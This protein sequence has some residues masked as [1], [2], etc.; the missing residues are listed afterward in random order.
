M[1][2][3]EFGEGDAPSPKPAMKRFARNIEVAQLLP[4]ESGLG[5]SRY[6]Q[7]ST[8]GPGGRQFVASQ[9]TF[10]E[11]PAGVY[12]VVAMDNLNR[13]I[14]EKQE[15]YVDDLIRMKDCISDKILYEIEDFWNRADKFKKHGILH[16]RGYL[17]YGSQG[18]GKTILVQQIISSMVEKGYVVFLCSEPTKALAGLKDFRVIEPERRL[19]CVFEDI[20]ALFARYGD[21]T[22]LSLLDGENQL[23]HTLNLATSN[24]PERLEKRIVCRPRRFDRVIKIDMPS[25]T[26]REQYFMAKLGNRSNVAE[27]VK[28]S[29]GL[30]FA[31][32]AELVVSVECLG[33]GLDE[34]VA[35]L[36]EMCRRSPSSDEFRGEVGFRK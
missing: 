14:L 2:F 6:T 12:V 29:E 36:A 17:L 13:P 32:L 33:R 21:E 4:V 24:Y 22:L 28:K 19:A 7:W 25:E 11:L 30:S 9:Q 20:D 15:R 34:S 16:R 26:I 31:A 5:G 35:M 8:F 23:D 18:T 3:E 27:W 10:S 1:A